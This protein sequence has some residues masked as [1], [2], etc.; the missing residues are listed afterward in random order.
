[1]EIV[2]R[3]SG[4]LDC[5]AESRLNEELSLIHGKSPS[6]V[7]FDI[8]SLRHLDPAGLECLGMSVNLTAS[9]GIEAVVQNIPAAQQNSHLHPLVNSKAYPSS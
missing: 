2:F 6:R 9:S 5:S 7:V 8:S 4:S 1:L 3:L